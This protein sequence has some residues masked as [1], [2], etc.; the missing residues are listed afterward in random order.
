[1]GVWQKKED[2]LAQLQ[3]L[4]YE[5]QQDAAAL[6][7]GY[8]DN[9]LDADVVRG[10][11]NV[12]AKQNKHENNCWRVTHNGE[13]KDPDREDLCFTAKRQ[14]KNADE[15]MR[16]IRNNDDFPGGGPQ[17]KH[18][19]PSEHI[20]AQAIWVLGSI[21]TDLSDKKEEIKKDL[22]DI[23]TSGLFGDNVILQAICALENL[24]LLSERELLSALSS[25]HPQTRWALIKALCRVEP[26][27]RTTGFLVNQLT[28]TTLSPALR[29]MI[30]SNLVN[31]SDE[32]IN[33]PLIGMLDDDNPNVRQHC[34][35]TLGEN[36]AQAA[37]TPLFQM[38]IDED[39]MVRLAAGV[40]LGCLGDTR[41]VPFLFRGMELGDLRIQKVAQKALDNM[42]SNATP[43]LVQALRV[44][45]M[46]YKMQALKMLRKLRDPRATLAI[47]ESLLD[48]D[49]ELEAQDIVVEFGDVMEKPL[50]YVAQSNDIDPLF[51]EKCIRL[52]IQ[53]KSPLSLTVL[54]AQLENDDDTMK[55]LAIN[56]MGDLPDPTTKDV[57]FEMLEQPLGGSEILS[58]LL[59]T[60][61]QQAMEPDPRFLPQEVI[62]EGMRQNEFLSELLL[63]LGKHGDVRAIP[64][65]LL[66]LEQWSARVY[67]YSIA[68]LGKIKAT[69]AV[70]K[71][72]S[73]L[74]D[75]KG[76]YKEQ[77]IQALADIGD[78]S[79]IDTLR[80]VIQLVQKEMEYR[81]DAPTSL[82]SYAIQALAKFQDTYVIS[83]ILNSWESELETAMLYLGDAAVPEL[84]D[85]LQ[86]AR[87]P[88]IKSMA[89]EALGLIAS[90]DSMGVLILALQDPD[91]DVRSMAAWSLGEVYTEVR[92]RS[93]LQSEAQKSIAQK[94]GS[95]DSP[96][97]L[98]SNEVGSED[99]VSQTTNADVETATS[100]SE[101]AEFVKAVKDEEGASSSDSDAD[102][103]E[104]NP[105]H[106]A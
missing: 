77:V 22:N 34:A 16:I 60:K 104:S 47:I 102:A 103:T 21:E 98:E 68:A 80:K 73:I 81:N 27:P 54:K 82:G 24:G 88:K 12:M 72:C 15:L 20:L 51:R 71:L 91:E 38:L 6:L 58:S 14:I 40:A 28:D 49:L 101:E 66:G 37:S 25:E 63:A 17:S 97:L 35:L 3:S 78:P 95:K 19:I 2:L 46:P 52:L 105:Q 48:E 61:E 76:R 79:A 30:A 29:S 13:L 90:P 93:A 70:P 75:K 8:N 106:Q 87:E 100:T 86:N 89:A 53:M 94:E 62:K 99:D 11:L 43:D 26:Q 36:R 92:R 83:L 64:S 33:G 1:M 31:V 57:L 39:E 69:D 74:M 18:T 85:A 7:V 50:A 67:S 5:K 84:I 10:L 4:N 41:T 44:E 32:R 23:I 9:I 45:K 59:K 55:L 65:M 96:P 42:G 56:L